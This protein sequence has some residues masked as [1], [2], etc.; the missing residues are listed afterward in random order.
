MMQG[1]TLQSA[2]PDSFS[3][4]KIKKAQPVLPLPTPFTGIW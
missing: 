1:V 2:K 3:L 4:S